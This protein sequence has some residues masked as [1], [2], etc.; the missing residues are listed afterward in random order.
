MY[1]FI[2]YVYMYVCMNE[3]YVYMN[4]CVHV[5]MNVCMNVCMYVCTYVCIFGLYK[6]V[7]G[8]VADPNHSKNRIPNSVACRLPHSLTDRTSYNPSIRRQDFLALIT[9]TV[10]KA[11]FLQPC[12]KRQNVPPY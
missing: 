4:V 6:R 5:C 12:R 8:N 9:F 2:M 1:V 3:M 11:R 10:T 7:A